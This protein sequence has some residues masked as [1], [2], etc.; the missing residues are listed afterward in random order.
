METAEAGGHIDLRGRLHMAEKIIK[1]KMEN[2]SWKVWTR[3]RIIF[4]LSFI[5]LMKASRKKHNNCVF[6]RIIKF[7]YKISFERDY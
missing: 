7:D 1:N 2:K 3:S 6:F 5:V 4:R